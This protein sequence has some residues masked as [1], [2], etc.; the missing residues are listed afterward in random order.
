MHAG[1]EYG[2]QASIG[3]SEGARGEGGA[4]EGGADEGGAGEGGAGEGGAGEREYLW[5]AG[6]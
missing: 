5:T 1:R 3:D 2:R 4:G 6:M